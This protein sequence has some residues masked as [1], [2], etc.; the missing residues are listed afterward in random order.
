MERARVTPSIPRSRRLLILELC[1]AKGALAFLPLV[2]LFNATIFFRLFHFSNFPQH[3][4]NL[5]RFLDFLF[6]SRDKLAAIKV[7]P[8]DYLINSL[9]AV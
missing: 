8:L 9:T 3:F 5:E 4:Q 6:F 2:Q 1:L 7:P